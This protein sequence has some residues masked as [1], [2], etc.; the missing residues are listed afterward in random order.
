M[1]ALALL[2]MCST[3]HA[4]DLGIALQEPTALPAM[5]GINPYVLSLDMID[6]PILP[7]TRRSA[8]F[9]GFSDRAYVGGTSPGEFAFYSLGVNLAYQV[10]G[11]ADDA[12]MVSLELPSPGIG[13]RSQNWL[14]AAQLVPA[15]DWFSQGQAPMRD[16]DHDFA[17]GLDAQ[18]CLQWNLGGF[19]PKNS[20]GCVYVAP[21]IYRE[22]FVSGGAF[23]VRL[24]TL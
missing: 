1:K 8:T 15:I 3:A 12:A 24:F 10:S 20:A 2:V 17:L 23:G 5:S 18:V 11:S 6:V 13:Y 9:A 7:T 16:R 22:G 19:F 4:D 14:V 21:Q